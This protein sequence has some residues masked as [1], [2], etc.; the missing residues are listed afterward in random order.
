MS[1]KLPD[2]EKGRELLVFSEDVLWL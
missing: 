2:L 1:T